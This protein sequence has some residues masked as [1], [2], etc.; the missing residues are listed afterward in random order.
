LKDLARRAVQLAESMGAVYGDCRVVHRQ[1][2]SLSVK[3]AAVESLSI[4]DDIGIGIRVIY[5]GCWGF[6]STTR[7]ADKSRDSLEKCVKRAV[8]TAKSGRFVRRRP[9]ELAPEPAHVCDWERP[10][11]I[12]PFG[13]DLSTKLELLT[14]CSQA[15]LSQG[16]RVGRATLS[17]RRDRQVFANT[18]GSLISQV[19]TESSGG[20]RATAVGFGRTKTR[21][22]PGSIGDDVQGK[23]WEAILERDLLRHAPQVGAEA[24]Q[25]LSARPCPEM[26]T[27]VIIAP[28]QLVLQ[29]HE[30][31]AHAVEADRVLGHEADFAG[32]SFVS[33]AM[34][35]N[36]RYG[37]EC[38]NFFADATIPGS[39]TSYMYDDEGVETRRV[40][41]VR[42]GVLVGLTTSR[43]TARLLGLDRSGGC[44]RAENYF[45]I[46]LV[47]MPNVSLAPGDVS[48]EDLLS[49]TESGLLL[50]ESGS[51]SIDDRRLNFQFCPEVGWIIKN[52]VLTEMVRDP[53]YSDMTPLFWRKCDAVANEK[54]W[55]VIGHSCG[56]GTPNQDGRVAHGTAHARFR[57]VRVGGRA[58]R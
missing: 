17:F 50:S 44:T 20:L 55:R 8:D 35:G 37:S 3:N 11:E 18:E 4:T 41:L 56:K 49:S 48:F 39:R 47:R 13:V 40:D 25:L 46:P 19:L 22:Y 30:S 38:V 29:I 52:G 43:E 2:E 7:V 26:T 45:N 12:D 32:T 57:G 9:V 28:S 14:R 10:V 16:A 33:P 21:S 36:F 23:G 27:D 6:A 54:D 31:F 53:I 5:E 15:M 24:V 1:K 42:Q 58:E 34:V 51:Y